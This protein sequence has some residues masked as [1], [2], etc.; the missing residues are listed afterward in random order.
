ML[1]DLVQRNIHLSDSFPGELVFKIHTKD[2]VDEL[3]VEVVGEEG[4][5]EA[6]FFD[7]RYADAPATAQMGFYRLPREVKAYSFVSW[8]PTYDSYTGY[9]ISVE[10]LDGKFRIAILSED[11]LEIDVHGFEDGHEYVIKELAERVD[12][13]DA[14]SYAS[15]VVDFP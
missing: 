10:K 4:T 3:P 5:L 12:K 2:L 15:L 14:A 8:D 1:F 6:E 7:S 13:G 11:D 9:G